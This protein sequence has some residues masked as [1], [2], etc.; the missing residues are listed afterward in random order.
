MET[1]ILLV[2]FLLGNKYVFAINLLTDTCVVINFTLEGQFTILKQ[3]VLL[4]LLTCVLAND[5][6]I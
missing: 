4:A 5:I 1:C 6:T 2:E 3:N